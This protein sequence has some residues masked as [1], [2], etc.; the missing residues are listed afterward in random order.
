MKKLAN[1]VYLLTLG[2]ALSLS[3]TGC[4]RLQ[5]TTHIPGHEPKPIGDQAAGPR[6]APDSGLSTTAPPVIGSQNT[7]GTAVN[8]DATGTGGLGATDKD[9]SNWKP[10]REVFKDQTVHFDFDQS[11]VKASEVPKLEEVARRMK[12]EFM[13]K[14]LRIEGHCDERGT[15]EYNR[16]LGDK[17][18]Q[19]VREKLAQFG[20]DASMMPTVTLGEEQP[21]D[22]GHN[23][24]AWK[25]NRRGELI[26]L[27]PPAPGAN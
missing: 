1:I 24:A 2:I 19:S 17:R 3:S 9:F 8:P 27:S 26:L 10:D 16:A 13:G 14:A 21:I 12:S 4:K 11:I 23:E 25:K 7:T 18:A 22:P 6:T 15:E 5:K 20:V